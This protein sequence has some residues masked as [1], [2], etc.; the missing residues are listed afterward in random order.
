MSKLCGFLL[1]QVM[2]EGETERI[3]DAMI[4]TMIHDPGQKSSRRIFPGGRGGFGR[5]RSA[6]ER[7]TSDASS[8]DGRWHLEH[9]GEVLR[10]A[11]DHRDSRGA[12]THRWSPDELLQ[13]W[14]QKPNDLLQ[15]TDGVFSLAVYDHLAQSLWVTVDRFGFCPLYYSQTPHG[16]WFA[17]EVK[18]L[19]AVLQTIEPDWAAWGDFF[20][21]GHM[22]GQ[23]TLCKGVNS[24][25]PGGIV[26]FP[27]EPV[28]SRRYFD[29]TKIDPLEDT[30]VS[31]EKLAHLF[32]QAVRRRLHTDC[33]NTMLLSGGFD[34]RLV[35]GALTEIGASPRVVSLE[36]RDEKKGLDG[37]IAK[38]VAHDLGLHVEFQ[39]TRPAFYNT[40]DWQVA[41]SILDGMVPSRNLFITQV[42]SALHTDMGFVWDGLALGLVLGGFHGCDGTPQQNLS[43]FASRRAKVRPHIE[44]LVDPSIFHAMD[45]GFEERLMALHDEIPASQIQFILFLTKHRTRRRIAINPYQLYAT[46][47]QP[48]CPGTDFE[49][50]SYI[51]AIPQHLKRHH[52]LYISLLRNHFPGLLTQPVCS[53]GEIF[54]SEKNPFLI[55]KHF[56]WKEG[57]RRELSRWPWLRGP[58]TATR[59]LRTKPPNHLPPD[60]LSPPPVSAPT[61]RGSAQSLPRPQDTG[62]TGPQ[63]DVFTYLHAWHQMFPYQEHRLASTSPGM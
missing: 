18:A 22:L 61:Y 63:R 56:D 11:G 4:A 52:K 2:A 55:A 57:L 44:E 31:T 24:I 29:F 1:D 50:L 9:T 20:Y 5:I 33:P 34:S 32:R 13:A 16:L 37:A 59:R 35:L 58:L 51:M 19:L 36:H 53:G 45:G 14:M 15:Q 60:Q 42:Y 28:S 26:S 39:S 40:N 43:D 54:L 49:F 17:S 38:R 7:G 48:T 12:L 8:P 3:L 47:I 62:D 10:F 6:A 21:V 27:E 30:D 25:E 46:R 41:Y 23:E